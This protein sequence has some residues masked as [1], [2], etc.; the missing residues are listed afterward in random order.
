[1]EE[2]DF[3]LEDDFSGLRESHYK[4]T[5]PRDPRYNCI[6]FAAG[7]LTNFWDDLG[8]AGSGVRG[9]Y[10]PPGAPSTDTLIGWVHVFQ[11]HGYIETV[12]RSL[13][14]EYEKIA[15]YVGSDGPEHV[16]RQKSSGIWTSKM[17]KGVD[18][19]HT[20]ESLEGDFY[21]KVEKIMKRKCQDGKRVL[22]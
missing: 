21:G 7:D 16:A 3:D 18:I 11:L 5:S 19:E 15:I 8:L 22:E 9:Y 4:I 1:M 17:G 10:W 6:A 2:R 13:E 14:I 12:D 20:L